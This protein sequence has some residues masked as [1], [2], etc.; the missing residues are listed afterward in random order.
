MI[1]VQAVPPPVVTPAQEREVFAN[2]PTF[3]AEGKNYAVF[4]FNLN[5]SDD[6]ISAAKSKLAG[7]GWGVEIANDQA[8]NKVLLVGAQRKTMAQVRELNQQF[9]QGIFG[10]LDV[11]PVILPVPESVK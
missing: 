9:Q 11:K 8:G 6:Q 7:L 2:L 1:A 3:Q 4:G 5:G 10:S